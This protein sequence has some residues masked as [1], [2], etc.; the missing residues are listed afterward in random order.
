MKKKSIVAQIAREEHEDRENRRQR[1]KR[2]RGHE[3]PR[4][5]ARS[6]RD[7]RTAGKHGDPNV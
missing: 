5:K 3:T 4:P 7:R 1:I 6:I 2:L